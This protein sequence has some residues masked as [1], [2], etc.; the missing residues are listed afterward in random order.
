MPKEGHL[1]TTR[2]RP[3]HRRRAAQVLLPP[4]LLTIM[5]H[6]ENDH[7]VDLLP[8]PHRIRL[9]SRPVPASWGVAIALCLALLGAFALYKYI[10]AAGSEFSSTSSVASSG[11][12]EPATVTVTLSGGHVSTIP[13]PGSSRATPTVSST[14]STSSSGNGTIGL[15]LS[16]VSKNNIGIGFLPD[17]NGQTMS[18]I[19]SGPEIKSSF[20]GCYQKRGIGTA[21]LMSQMSDI[22]S[23]SCIFQP[24]VMPTT[25]W[26]GLTSSDNSQALAIA[27]VMQQFTNEGIEV[28]LRFAHEG[29]PDRLTDGTYQGTADDFKEGWAAVAAAVADNDLVKISLDDYL[30]YMLNDTSTIDYIGFTD[31]MQGLYDQ[32]CKDGTIKFAIGETGIFFQYSRVAA[33]QTWM[34]WNHRRTTGLARADHKRGNCGRDAELRWRRASSST[35]S[36]V[37]YP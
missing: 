27:K 30:A 5:V 25:G 31:T 34:E 37:P 8:I 4:P 9:S 36:T 3:I 23:C 20:Y 33:P 18:D 17:Y 12:S 28:W 16:G 29:P 26:T 2:L 7:E 21:Q 10:G 35:I 15:T 19:T 6:L 32:H 13:K 14:S 22:K 11:G 24:A 1:P